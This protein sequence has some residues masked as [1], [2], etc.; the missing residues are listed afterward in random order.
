MPI[1]I[2]LPMRGMRGLSKDYEL[3]SKIHTNEIIK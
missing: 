3:F 2:E 1:E